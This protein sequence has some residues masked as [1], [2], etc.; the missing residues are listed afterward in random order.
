MSSE[1]LQA[2]PQIDEHWFFRT[3]RALRHPSRL[4]LLSI[5]TTAMIWEVAMGDGIWS[6]IL[7]T[8]VGVV[9]G[10]VVGRKDYRLPVVMGV[11]L[12]SWLLAQSWWMWESTR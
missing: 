8:C 4:V 6:A 1:A 12:G 5:A 11:F 3:I 10:E 7:G 9:V 2:E